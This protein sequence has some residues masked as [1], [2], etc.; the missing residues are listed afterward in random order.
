MAY[1]AVLFLASKGHLNPIAPVWD[2]SLDAEHGEME[3]V[4]W[5]NLVWMF[6][7]T[8]PLAF[9][10][11]LVRYKRIWWIASCAAGLT[12]LPYLFSAHE[13]YEAGGGWL[14]RFTWQVEAIEI[15]FVPLI[16]LGLARP[17]ASRMRRVFRNAS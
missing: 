4:H 16:L 2:L 15:V 11:A 17:V 14:V 1:T 7:V 12:A 3:L 10:C 13:T 8:S 5:V 6:V 9:L